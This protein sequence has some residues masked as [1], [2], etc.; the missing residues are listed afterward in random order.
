MGIKETLKKIKEHHSHPYC[1]LFPILRFAA[2]NVIYFA[3]CRKMS[4]I[5]A[6]VAYTE[7]RDF[8]SSSERENS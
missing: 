4:E 1:F 2:K 5:C 6:C 7:N 3:E 8:H